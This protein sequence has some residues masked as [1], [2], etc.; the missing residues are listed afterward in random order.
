VFLVDDDE[1]EGDVVGAG[2]G[3]REGGEDGGAGA[4]DD[5]DVAPADALPFVA[6]LCGGEA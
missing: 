4:D 3:G 2:V 5:G 1:S 6:A